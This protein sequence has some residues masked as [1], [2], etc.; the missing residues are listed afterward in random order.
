M[1]EGH[2]QGGNGMEEW[3]GEMDA[4]IRFNIHIK[5]S[6]FIAFSESEKGNPRIPSLLESLGTHNKNEMKV[7]ISSSRYRSESPS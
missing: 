6:M 5:K 1:V 2:G 4:F 3:R 7:R